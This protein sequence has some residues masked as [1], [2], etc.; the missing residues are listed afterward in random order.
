MYHKIK[1][2][3]R[4]ILE[5]SV[6]ERSCLHPLPVK[7]FEA[8][9]TVEANVGS[10]LTF[11]FDTVKYSLPLEYSGKTVA[12][13][14]FPYEIE[15]W[16]KGRLVYRHIRPFAK[17]ENRHIPEHYLP[18]LEKRPRARGNAAP[19]KYGVLP[20][21]LE[22]F[23]SKCADKDKYEQLA[24]ILLLG[25][26]IDSRL[27]LEAVDFANKTG[28]PSFNKVKFF[29]DLKESPT[30]ASEVDPVTVQLRD[31]KQY[32]ALLGMEESANE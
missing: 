30:Q 19:I 27:L 12:L 8:Y 15:A 24:N 10:D 23:R 11:R 22:K 29:L 20:P 26:D 18:L 1:D 3:K 25:R 14:I 16:Y 9:T 4:A 21:E 13:R 17:Y 31:L 7:R 32:D 28:I 5:M 2:R 6:E